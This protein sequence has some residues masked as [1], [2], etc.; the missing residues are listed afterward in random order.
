MTAMSSETESSKIAGAA[1]QGGG[2]PSAVDSHWL[3][4][5]AL[6]AGAEDV[7]FVSIDREEIAEERPHI[8]EAFP[9]TRTLISIVTRLNPDNVR[10][11]QRSIGNL[12]FHRNYEHVNHV[13]AEIVRRLARH[14]I[15]AVNPSAAFPMEMDEYPGRI[16]VVALKPVAVAAGLGQMGIHRSVIHPKF[17][18][19]IN[20]GVVLIDADVTTQT[21]PIDFN[22]C[23]SC[24]LCVAACPVGA[25][26]PDGYF[27]FGACFTHN[28]REFMGGFTDWVETIAESRDARALRSKVSD[29]EQSSMWQSLSFGANYKAAYCI[30]VC[31]AGEDVIGPYNAD[32]AAFAREVL[33]PLVQKKEPL[34]VVAG[35]DAEDY[36]R[37]RF[38][39]K[40]IRLVGGGLRPRTIDGFLQGLSLVFQRGKAK[41]LE[42]I[43]HFTFTGTQSRKATVVVRNR[44]LA[45][46][47]GHV[48]KADIA[49]VTESKSWL[50]FVYKERSLASMLLTGRLRIKGPPKL[51]LAFGRCFAT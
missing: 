3:R 16:W 43:Y 21:R 46:S 8:L 40:A 24:K 15:R 29:A 47:D 42:A 49:V 32:R 48:G 5:L 4:E 20:L 22:P 25:I 11:S 33:D 10:S 45:I 23:L 37:R 44:Q 50:A 35:S 9:R 36:A 7:G 17:G 34:Y 41:G 13:A 19:F 39:H 1:P 6:E 12:E 26:A 31:P 27:N 14:G 51:L 38:P 30:A 18:S 2:A 28:Y